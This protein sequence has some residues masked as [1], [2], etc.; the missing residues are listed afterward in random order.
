MTNDAAETRFEITSLGWF[1]LAQQ[2]HAELLQCSDPKKAMSLD[3]EIRYGMR[4]ALQH[5]L[6]AR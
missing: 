6:N 4:M 2:R 3:E 5:A 1:Y